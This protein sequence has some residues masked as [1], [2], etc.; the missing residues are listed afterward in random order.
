MGGAVADDGTIIRTR[1][2]SSIVPFLSQRTLPTLAVHWPAGV[3]RRPVESERGPK[4]SR[5]RRAG[6]SARRDKVALAGLFVL[7]A[8]L[9]EDLPWRRRVWRQ[10]EAGDPCVGHC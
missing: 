2:T 8:R 3:E 7:P 4:P 6:W 9:R 10:E 1:G 5:T